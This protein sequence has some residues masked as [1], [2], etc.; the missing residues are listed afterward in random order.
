MARRQL[1]AA[2]VTEAM[3]DHWLRRGRLF[4]LHRAV[5]ALGHE[6]VG[7]RGREL[8]AVLAVGDGAL[9]SHQSAPASEASGRPG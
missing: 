1:L 5:Y 9:L 8:A 6:G 2:G 7:L 3:V 4:P